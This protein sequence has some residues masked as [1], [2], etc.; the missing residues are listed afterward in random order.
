MAKVKKQVG[1]VQST[2]KLVSS[3]TRNY[4]KA[5]VGSQIW[6]KARL[7]RAAASKA[8]LNVLGFYL[9]SG[10]MTASQMNPSH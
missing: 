5:E 10:T 3:K 8:R 4:M 6:V 1:T 2:L 9:Q 7:S